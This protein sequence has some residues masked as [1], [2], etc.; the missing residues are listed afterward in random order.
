MS[1]AIFESLTSHVDW[2]TPDDRTDRPALG[3]IHGTDGTLL[4]EGGASVVH[5]T[6]FLGELDQRGRPPVVAI[7]LTHWHWDHSFG[8]AAARVPVAGHRERA[9]ELELQAGYD[10]SDTALDQRVADGLEIAFCRDMMKLE[11]PDR[12]DLEIVVPSVIF[13]ERHT[14]DLGG[15]TVVV[16]HV[17]GDHAADSCIVYVPD[18]EVIFLGDCLYQRLHAP[19]EYLTISGV[20]DLTARLG[21]F[22]VSWAI[23]GHGGKV[24]DAQAFQ[25]R[26]AELRHAADLLE[27]RGSAASEHAAGDE[28]LIE[29]VELLLVG[30]ERAAVL[31][32]GTIVHRRT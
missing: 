23:E 21:R 27:A 4:V 10:W 26:L 22:D 29:L 2:F 16:E 12:A 18:D 5:L 1:D 6:S 31:M 3:A 24:A 32:G 20:R 15:V 7:A 28:E 25:A 9:R 8:S 14:F 19:P 13:D 30:E 11:I 17:G